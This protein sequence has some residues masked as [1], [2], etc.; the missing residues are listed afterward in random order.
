MSSMALKCEFLLAKAG[1]V[2]GSCA[3][4]LVLSY[5]DLLLAS[6]SGRCP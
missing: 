4:D 6:F 3:S 1:S 2:P 5:E